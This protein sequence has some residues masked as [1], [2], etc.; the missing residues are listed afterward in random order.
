MLNIELQG[1]QQTVYG[2]FY[3]KETICVTLKCYTLFT[4]PLK[5]K[6]SPTAST[7]LALQNFC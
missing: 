4:I 7:V 2:I 3:M 6:K 1:V 5:T